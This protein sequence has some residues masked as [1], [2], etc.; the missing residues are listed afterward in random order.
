MR[1]LMTNVRLDQR[2]GTEI[3]TR[4][5]A[6]AL[7]RAGHAVVVYCPAPGAV[8]EEIQAGGVAVVS[9][10]ESVP[11]TPEVI[12]GHHHVET[13]AAVFRY[14]QV[15]AL[16]VC[17]DH[18]AWHDRPPQAETIRRYVAVD[19]PQARLR[20]YEFARERGIVT[21]YNA[22]DLDR[23]GRRA[24]LPAQPRRALV[25]SNYDKFGPELDLLRG[26]CLRNDIELDL[27]GSAT[28]GQATQPE[29]LLPGYDLVFGRG[30]CA[31]EAA[32]SG[33]AVVLYEGRMLG[34]ML[35]P[36]VVRDALEWNCGRRYLRSLLSAEEVQLR[37]RQYDPPA[38]RRV[39]DFVRRHRSLS[40]A[41]QQWESLYREVMD[42]HR[43]AGSPAAQLS[44]YAVPM[45][46]EL[47]EVESNSTTARMP[48]LP[49]SVA[50]ELELECQYVRVSVPPL[51]EIP[52]RVKL[53]NHSIARL[54]E[55]KPNPV[56]IGYRWFPAEGPGFEGA[57][58]GALIPPCEPGSS[59][60]YAFDLPAPETPGRYRM[61]ITM[62]QEGV[63]W[64]DEC[65]GRPYVDFLVDVKPREMER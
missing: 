31:M 53:T 6:L 20:R 3:V 35:S 56:R 54:T 33:C 59:E 40:G 55:A 15:P 21:I 61:R 9:D 44:T 27:A 29:L 17:H 45:L 62:V 34:P 7:H 46:K 38:A 36:D 2:T 39:S 10:F 12:H 63:G 37:L 4:D 51:A 25:F 14:P 8:A 65:A 18:T 19:A 60:E 11:F 28:G 23:F 57:R 43:A 22:V 50:G 5:L 52:L 42:E 58:R 32:V 16:F 64:F 26:E 24:P 47:A 1:I 30:R 13:M 49:V 41:V 48:P